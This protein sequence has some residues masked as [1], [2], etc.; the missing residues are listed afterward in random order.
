MP[1]CVRT[2]VLVWQ[3]RT[4][5]LSMGARKANAAQQD[6]IGVGSHAS[7]YVRPMRCMRAACAPSIA[8]SAVLRSVSG[9]PPELNAMATMSSE[10]WQRMHARH[11][12]VPN[13][14][15]AAAERAT[16]EVA[17]GSPMSAAESET[18]AEMPPSEVSTDGDDIESP[19]RR[20]RRAETLAA[21][22]RP[23]DYPS[24]SVP[25]AASSAR[26]ALR[27][28]A[29]G[30]VRTTPTI[31]CGA[32]QPTTSRRSA[33]VPLLRIVAHAFGSRSARCAARMCRIRV[34]QRHD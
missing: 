6:G 13:E 20:L 15:A 5:P 25:R 18:D 4:P 33:R 2:F 19:A 27:V 34:E 11:F 21:V 17:V 26:D 12:T 16:D 9:T 22:G 1:R 30:R 10:G 23:P 3:A 32:A 8:K 31:L 7:R 28:P 24:G 14:A 29:A